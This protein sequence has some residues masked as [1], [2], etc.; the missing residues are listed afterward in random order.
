M[1]A[2]ILAAGMGKR[3]G[4]YTRDCTKCMVKVGSVRLIDRTVDALKQAGIH[5]LIMVVGFEGKQL[6]SYLRETVRDMDIIFIYN[7][8]YQKTNNIYSLFLA[9]DELEKD[10]TILLESDLIFDK[11]I[12]SEIVKEPYD[13]MV[14]VA[15]YEHWMDGTVVLLDSERNIIDFVAKADF[16]YEEVEDYYKTVNIYKFSKEFSKTQYIP[17]LEAYIKAYGVNQYYELVLK[18]LAHV[19][20]SQLKAFILEDNNWYEIDDV[21]DLRIAETIFAEDDKQFHAYD[22]NYGG[23][24]RFPKLRDFCYLVNPYYPPKKMVDHM[25][26]FYET[27]LREYPSGL[28]TQNLNAARMFGVEE[29][30]ILVGNGAAE[31]INVLGEVL[32]GNL[33]TVVP[34]FN[35][36][37]RCFKNCTIHELYSSEVDFKLSCDDILKKINGMN[38]VALINPDN[39]SGSF[40]LQEDMLRIVEECRKRDV[41]CIVDES[42]VDFAEGGIRYTLLDDGLL[43]DYPNLLVIKSISKSY[44][45]P[46][47]RLGIAA[48]ANTGL[49]QKMRGQMPIW[50]VNSMAEYFLQIHG[51]YADDYLAA[52]D[53]I[54]KERSRMSAELEKLKGLRVYPSQANYIMCCISGNTNAKDV[55]NILVKEYNILIKDLTEK[56]GIPSEGYIRLA[57]KNR[58]ENDELI[59]ALK[60]IL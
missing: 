36:Y 7:S 50:N 46:G 4:K 3:L 39:P 14:T 42:F 5:R 56:K 59:R 58:E 19:Q 48:S 31:L 60:S 44:G 33:L 10:D 23:F 9:K 18:I 37:I 28:Q 26:Y 57:V 20:Y 47:L 43:Q 53:K 15:K 8:D 12:I 17:F 55:A 49:L 16:R 29:S 52:C 2:M 13:N 6:E 30:Y 11:G 38:A 1:Q 32:E 40:I 21:Q 27:L 22:H 41:L 24:W 45:V 51:L 35:E 34:V 25:K 54:A